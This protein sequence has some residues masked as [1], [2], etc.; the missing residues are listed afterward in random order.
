MD[1]NISGDQ[2]HR[3]NITIYSDSKTFRTYFA[4]TGQPQDSCHPYTYPKKEQQRFNLSC[5]YIISSFVFPQQ[6]LVFIFNLWNFQIACFSSFSET[7][8]EENWRKL[9]LKTFFGNSLQGL[10]GAKKQVFRNRMPNL[11]SCQFFIFTK[12]CNRKH[13]IK[14]TPNVKFGKN[15]QTI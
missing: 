13:H 6:F 8:G 5:A 9:K 12:K 4:K 3:K 1:K 15:Y 2:S 7:M 10:S 14:K 11:I